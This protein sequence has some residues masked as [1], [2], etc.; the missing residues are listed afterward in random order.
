[1]SLIPAVLR[2][3]AMPFELWLMLAFALIAFGGTTLISSY[4]RRGNS[5]R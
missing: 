1:M 5:G 4:E 2:P 3:R